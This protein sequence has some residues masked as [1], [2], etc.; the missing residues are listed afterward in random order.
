[1]QP[2]SGRHRF[3]PRFKLGLWVVLGAVA[4]VVTL[5]VADLF[6]GDPADQASDRL[7]SIEPTE[8]DRKSAPH[9]DTQKKTGRLQVL[10]GALVDSSR[11]AA[12]IEATFRLHTYLALRD[13]YRASIGLDWSPAAPRLSRSEVIQRRCDFGA[14][15]SAI[16]DSGTLPD[17]LG[18]TVDAMNDHRLFFVVGGS[19][20]ALQVEAV[21][22]NRQGSQKIQIAR[23][24][25]GTEGQ[26]VRELA[27]WAAAI[28]DSAEP[29]PLADSWSST[30]DLGQPGLGRYG[31]LLVG[32]TGNTSSAHSILVEAS[33]VLPEASWLL[34]Q[35]GPERDA[36]VHLRNA[37]LKRSGFTAAIEDRAVLLLSEGQTESALRELSLLE[38]TADSRTYPRP[39]RTLVAAKMIDIGRPMAALHVTESLLPKQQLQ[40]SAARIAA[41]ANLEL[42]RDH[43][44][45]DQVEI[46]LSAQPQSG[47][48]LLAAGRLRAAADNWTG[49][50]DA[51]TQLVL[52]HPRLRDEGLRDWTEVA[53]DRGDTAQ[54][55]EVLNELEGPTSTTRLSSFGLELKAYLAALSG[56]QSEALAIYDR[57]AARDQPTASTMQNRCQVALEAGEEDQAQGRCA[58]LRPADLEGALSSTAFDS[59]RPGLLPG[60]QLDTTKAAL[61]AR[62]RAPRSRDVAITALHSLSPTAP[63]ELREELLAR[64]RIAV[65]RGLAV[66]AGIDSPPDSRP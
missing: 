18:R 26:A 9:P 3:L 42:A 2:D 10:P 29:G 60:Y 34:A 64:W 65:G 19:E 17:P 58:G 11:T 7:S 55:Q 13:V 38:L 25:A 40:P 14:E 47:D 15:P 39:V 46:W 57:L 33:H 61:F 36:L 20:S 1:M 41:L 24:Q 4:V 31:E 43:S 50:G 66:P 22:C 28:T 48:A 45:A 53:L 44:A 16:L 5:P 32:S 8:S 62:K 49:A 54:L 37:R 30:L 6:W 59:R 51:W 52:K 63:P 35:L 56:R 12:G 23:V 21:L 27:T